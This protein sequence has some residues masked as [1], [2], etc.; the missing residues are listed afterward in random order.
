LPSKDVTL[1]QHISYFLNKNIPSHT[2][3]Y[4]ILN[5]TQ[6]TL[7]SNP[8]KK[9]IMYDYSGGHTYEEMRMISLINGT[10]YRV[11]LFGEPGMFLD[12]VPNSPKDD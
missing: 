4:K 1:D 12:Y 8:A 9:I 11:G 3:Y 6:S 7:A 5:S 2:D 10:S